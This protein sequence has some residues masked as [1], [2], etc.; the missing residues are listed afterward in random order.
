MAIERERFY[1]EL[2]TLP[3][4]DPDGPHVRALRLC[5]LGNEAIVDRLIEFQRQ[6]CRGLSREEAA[7][8]ALKEF[9]IDLNS[10]D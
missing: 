3:P 9:L 6:R 4:Y 2:A 10:S 1:A 7:E 8:Q 5:A